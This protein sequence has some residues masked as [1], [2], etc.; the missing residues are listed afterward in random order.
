MSLIEFNNSEFV[1]GT[2]NPFE[3]V[4]VW[5]SYK[6][7]FF[8]IARGNRPRWFFIRVCL[9]ASMARHEICFRIQFSSTVSEPG[10]RT[11]N[12]ENILH[13]STHQVINHLIVIFKRWS[14]TFASSQQS[15]F[16]FTWYRYFV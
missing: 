4:V 2:R 7:N 10:T 1:F 8:E 9:L 14:L 3:L 12:S 6:P 11:W 5:N 16:V 13:R 15:R